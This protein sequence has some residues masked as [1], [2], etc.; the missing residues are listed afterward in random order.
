ML[1]REAVGD[2]YRAEEM[3]SQASGATVRA[4][5]VASFRATLAAGLA[6]YPLGGP[7]GPSPPPAPT[8]WQPP[9]EQETPDE[10]FIKL[11]EQTAAADESELEDPS[12]VSAL[13]I[14]LAHSQQSQDVAPAGP[15][16][17]DD[18]EEIFGEPEKQQLEAGDLAELV[19][20]KSCSN[21]RD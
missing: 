8:S 21:T 5:T 2:A 7:R 12:A 18:W 11:V 14:R 20:Q 13:S 19:F 1:V 17:S 6:Q 9:A 16:W 4:S 15:T 3:R 10:K